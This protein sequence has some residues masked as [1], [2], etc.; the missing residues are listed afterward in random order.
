MGLSTLGAVAVPLPFLSFGGCFPKRFSSLALR[1][2][3]AT[4]LSSPTFLAT[5]RESSGGMR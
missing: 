2:F 1:L 4:A 5:C 3:L